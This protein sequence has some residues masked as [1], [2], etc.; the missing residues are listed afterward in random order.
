[1]N[2]AV[3]TGASSGMGKEFAIRVDKENLDEIWAI[4]L[5][6]EG[7]EK[8]K[9]KLKTKVKLFPM[10]LTNEE[11]FD[12]INKTLEESKPNIKWLVNASGFGKFGRNT[13]IETKALTN[14]IDL[15]CKALVRLTQDCLKYMQEGAKIVQFGSV[16][17]FQP[18][19]FISVYGATKAFVLSYSR[20]LNMELKPRKISVTCVCPFW[21]KTQFFK[22]AVDP[23]NAVVKKY[24]VMYDAGK[25]IDKAY[26]DAVK[27]KEISIYGVKARNQVRLVKLLPHKLV[28]KIWMKQ[29]KLK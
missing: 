14:M 12:K 18:I 25:V 6:I 7:L 27:G 3:V 2:I 16:A 22:R 26:K 21:T 24:I 5:D 8:L 9:E 23:K 28:M 13:D 17:S 10:D 1:M 4:A 19:P 11:S 29:Q 20:S 15:N